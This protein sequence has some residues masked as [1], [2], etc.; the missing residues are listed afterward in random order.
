MLLKTLKKTGLI[1][2]CAT[3][4][5]SC[6]IFDSQ[7]DLPVGKRISIIEKSQPLN[8]KA[9]NLNIEIPSMSF[10]NNWSQ[11]GGNSVHI[12]QNLSGNNNM[13][14]VWEANFGKGENKRN[15]LLAQPII[16]GDYVYAQDV[17]ATVSAFEIAS[18]KKVWKT[19][20][21]PENKNISDN[22]LNGVGLASDGQS[23]FALTGFGSIVSLDKLNGQQLWRIETKTPL[24]TAPTVCNNKLII[25]TLDNKLIILSTK[26]GSQINKY[27]ISSEDTVLAGGATPAC[28]VENDIIVAGF[29]NGYIESFN[30]SIGYPLWTASIINNKR[31]NSSTNI[32]AIKASPIIDEELVYAIGNNDMLVALDYRSGETV[33]SQEIGSTNTPWLAGNYLYVVTNNNELIALDKYTGEVMFN[34]FILQD[35]TLEERTD[36]YLSGPIM[37]NNKLLIT[38]SN[39]VVYI[40]SASNGI[41]E[42]TIDTKNNLPYAP[43]SANDTV[44]FVNSDADII[45]YR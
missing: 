41:I 26:D 43:I 17:E 6:S 21:K 10:S 12:M 40:V 42:H 20:I 34:T 32:N 9:G 27:D 29:S 33:W 28:S 37:V 38:S 11:T 8:A 18:G 2:C 24:R 15:L 36:I 19:K 3:L 5:C 23:I 22:G 16:I 35:Y 39:G 31:G 7:K 45:A 1:F 44:I 13:K 25:Q 4:M 14:K 30:L